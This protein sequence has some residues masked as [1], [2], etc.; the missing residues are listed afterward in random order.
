MVVSSILTPVVIIGEKYSFRYPVAELVL[1]TEK[2]LIIFDTGFP[3]GNELAD[4]LDTLLLDRDDFTYVFNTH[5]HID[6]YGGN[7]LFR[8]ARNILSKRDYFFS[9]SEGPING[10]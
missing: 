1:K 3:E 7:R 5:I 2:D 8:N 10:Y 4:A 6:H 9:E